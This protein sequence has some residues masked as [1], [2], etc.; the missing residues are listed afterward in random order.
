MA[1]SPNGELVKVSLVITKEQDR[2]L[3]AIHSLK[4]T[5]VNRLSFSDV[6]RDVVEKGLGV[7][8]RELVS[9]STASQEDARESA[10]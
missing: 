9:N 2:R 10:A 3:R 4:R 7:I 5:D 6:G 8:S 1:L